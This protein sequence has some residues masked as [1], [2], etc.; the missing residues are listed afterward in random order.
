MQCIPENCNEKYDALRHWRLQLLSLIM[1]AVVM[2]GYTYLHCQ[3][4]QSYFPNP[5]ALL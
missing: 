3:T 5:K 4:D 1:S 2:A